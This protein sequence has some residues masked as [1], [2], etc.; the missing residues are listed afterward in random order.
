MLFI[1]HFPIFYSY[2]LFLFMYHITVDY[3]GTFAIC[4]VS[5]V[6]EKGVPFKEQSFNSCD[7]LT[8]AMVLGAFRTVEEHH[9]R[10]Q[11]LKK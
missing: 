9:K 8:K 2:F 4:K 10:E 11:K 7:S 1:V 5:G 3:D 6:D